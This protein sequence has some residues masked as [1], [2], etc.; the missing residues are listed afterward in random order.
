MDFFNFSIFGK[1]L[2][3][4]LKNW[5]LGK[6]LHKQWRIYCDKT[7]KCVKLPCVISSHLLSVLS[8]KGPG[9]WD[10]LWEQVNRLDSPTEL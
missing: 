10:I 4:I 3:L 8:V 6:R 9:T 7:V 2:E 5:S 1:K